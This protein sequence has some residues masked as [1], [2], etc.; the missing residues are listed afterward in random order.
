MKGPGVRLDLDV[1]RVWRCP[2]CGRETRSEGQVVLRLCGC[3][4][5]GIAMRLMELP[6][7]MPT[8]RVPQPP[9]AD[10][11][12]PQ[13]ADFPTDIPVNPPPQ[14]APAESPEAR[15]EP[16]D[17]EQEPSDNEQEPPDN[18]AGSTNTDE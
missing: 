12:I 8:V 17:N 6:R 15:Q 18:E 3:T 13:L 5:E 14:R 1:R 16:S 4:K 2:A 10:A 7:P 11:D 9:S